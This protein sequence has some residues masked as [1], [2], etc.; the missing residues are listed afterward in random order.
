MHDHVMN[1]FRV[2]LM[3]A[4][5]KNISHTLTMSKHEKQPT[6]KYVQRIKHSLPK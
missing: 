6:H 4:R 2:C 3:Y 1:V 5:L